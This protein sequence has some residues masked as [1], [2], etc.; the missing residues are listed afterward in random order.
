MWTALIRIRKQGPGLL[1]SRPL[2][3]GTTLPIHQTDRAGR[4][5][6]I[7]LT[8]SGVMQFVMQARTRSGL[9]ADILDSAV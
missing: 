5:L 9:H 6:D 8:Y 3:A 1:L 2:A 7:L 4:V